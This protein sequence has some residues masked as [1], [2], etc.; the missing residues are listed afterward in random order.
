M[1]AFYSRVL[2][3]DSGRADPVPRNRAAACGGRA[4]APCVGRK[5]G[6][7]GARS[8]ARR[9]PTPASDAV[10]IRG[11][12]A[13]PRRER[14]TPRPRES[15][16]PGGMLLG[17]GQRGCG[18]DDTGRRSPVTSRDLSPQP[19]RFASLQACVGMI[20]RMSG[21][22]GRIAR[23]GSRCVARAFTQTSACLHEANA[24]ATRCAP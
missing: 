21:T 10:T 22:L 23:A 4:A 24:G 5:R 18:L 16:S 19:P 1:A 2:L 14:L 12:S 9:Q 13:A 15:G 3:Q 6:A 20:R 8:D 17:A 11:K 7:S